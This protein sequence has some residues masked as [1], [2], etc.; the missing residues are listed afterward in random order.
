MEPV[1]MD[2]LNFGWVIDDK[3]TGCAGPVSD[4]ELTLLKKKGITSIVRLAQKYSAQ[5][6][7][8]QVVRAGLKDFHEPIRDF[9]APS[10]KQIDRIV[11]H[12]KQS[13]ANGERVAVCCDAGIG[14]TG[15]VL[16]C[17]LISLCSTLDQARAR[18]LRISFIIMGDT[19]F[20]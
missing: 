17:T 18:Q 19:L 1:F 2:P 3:L 5:V 10:Q 4:S 15:L 6:T 16:T 12:I 14:R 9:G 20:R 11:G 7:S 8:E 13:M